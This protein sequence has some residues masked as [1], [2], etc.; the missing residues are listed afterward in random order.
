M[1]FLITY[2]NSFWFQNKINTRVKIK[3]ILIPIFIIQINNLFS[4]I[5]LI[6]ILTFWW[7]MNII[8]DF[9]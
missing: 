3:S 2:N 5:I 8:I 7:S 4:I 9:G 1:N 6:L